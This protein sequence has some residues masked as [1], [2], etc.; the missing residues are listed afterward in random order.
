[1]ADSEVT[2]QSDND[3]NRITY[4]TPNATTRNV[5][6]DVSKIDIK[7]S[8]VINNNVTKITAT[9]PGFAKTTLALQYVVTNL[10]TASQAHNA[11]IVPAPVQCSAPRAA[12]NDECLIATL[13]ELSAGNVTIAIL[14]ISSLNA[15]PTRLLHFADIIEQG[16]LTDRSRRACLATN[17]GSAPPSLL[18]LADSS[19]AASYH[20]PDNIIDSELRRITG[21]N[22]NR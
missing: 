1:M 18:D 16:D 15:Q 10:V 6:K 14:P 17:V 12:D 13:R 8:N 11:K 19:V 21:R 7:K 3:T 22:V 5:T 9:I 20:V 2:N 4:M